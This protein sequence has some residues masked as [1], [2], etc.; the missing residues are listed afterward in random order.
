MLIKAQKNAESEDPKVVRAKNGKIMFLPRCA[1]CDSNK[2]K[3]I[4]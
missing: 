1:V 2:S 3:F 4:K